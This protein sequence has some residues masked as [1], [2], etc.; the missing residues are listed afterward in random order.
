MPLPPTAPT[1]ERVLDPAD[2]ET[3][4][5]ILSQG[6]EPDDMLSPGEDVQSFTLA[7][8]PEAVAVGLLIKTGGGYTTALDGLDV[9]FWLE[10]DSGE[11]ADPRFDGAG[12][13]VGLE[14][15]IDTTSS[16]MRRKQRTVAVNIANQ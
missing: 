2:I 3:F 1:F 11:Q 16:P 4:R 7:L 6:T 10:V 14:L 13:T 15:T 9:D 5:I 8:T 12:V